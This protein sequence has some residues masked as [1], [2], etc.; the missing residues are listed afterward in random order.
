M[1]TVIREFKRLAKLA[2]EIQ[3]HEMERFWKPYSTMNPN[4]HRSQCKKCKML[5]DIN[6]NEIGNN[7]IIQNK[8]KGQK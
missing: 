6:D 8:C 1:P 7:T 3:G 4:Y 5:L 2:A